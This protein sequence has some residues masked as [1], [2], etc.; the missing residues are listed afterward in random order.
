MPG[1]SRSEEGLERVSQGRSSSFRVLE[2]HSEP[3]NVQSLSM[4]PRVLEGSKGKRG[5][6]F[7]GFVS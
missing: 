7:S 5:S 2:E 6:Q 1:T 4:S 3:E